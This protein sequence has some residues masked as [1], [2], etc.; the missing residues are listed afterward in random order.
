MDS[1]LVAGVECGVIELELELK[2]VMVVAV[3]C[4]TGRGSIA[5]M[6]VALVVGVQTEVCFG[7]S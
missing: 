3:S 7:C 4:D 2:A 1:H 5:S 6:E